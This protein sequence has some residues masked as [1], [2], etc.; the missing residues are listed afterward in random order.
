MNGIKTPITKVIPYIIIILFKMVAGHNSGELPGFR[1]DSR[2]VMPEAVQKKGL[3]SLLL[4]KILESLR[5]AAGSL[6]RCITLP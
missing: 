5:K 2:F 4:R 6:G 1:P 3:G